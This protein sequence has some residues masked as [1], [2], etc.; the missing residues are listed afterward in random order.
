MP[1]IFDNIAQ[2]LLPALAETL[3]GPTD[4]DEAGLR[5]LSA[6]IKTRKAVSIR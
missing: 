4:T 3:G 2:D 5:R 6:R 1:R